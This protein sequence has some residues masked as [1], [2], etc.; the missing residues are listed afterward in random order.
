[1]KVEFKISESLKKKLQV[2]KKKIA[3]NLEKAALDEM[4]IIKQRTEQGKDVDSKTFAPYV[5]S[6]AKRRQKLNRRVA[7]PNLR[8]TGKMISAMQVEKPVI[9]G[10]KIETKIYFTNQNARDKALG[11]MMKRDFF[12]LSEKQIARIKKRTFRD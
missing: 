11:N 6:Y 3:E 10:D 5:P 2:D 8:V 9:K 4:A 12:S 7:P 1:M